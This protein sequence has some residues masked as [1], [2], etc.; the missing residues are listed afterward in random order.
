M[1][2]VINHLTNVISPRRG[3]VSRFYRPLINSS[4]I[5]SRPRYQE[6]YSMPEWGV[7]KTRIEEGSDRQTNQVMNLIFPNCNYAAYL[8][9]INWLFYIVLSF[10]NYD[11][12]FNDMLL[13]L[14]FEFNSI[15]QF[16][17]KAQLSK[18]I[19]IFDSAS[20]FYKF[21]LLY[22]DGESEKLFP[23]SSVI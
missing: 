21:T 22:L 6:G 8:R 4:E 10:M 18:V 17:F 14:F 3:P 19:C 12:P 11:W 5:W 13:F 1:W 23:R 20:P 15:R 9:Q 16:I 2:D 7:Y